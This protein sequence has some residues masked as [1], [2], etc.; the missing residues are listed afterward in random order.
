[1][2]LK[3]C[4]FMFRALAVL[5]FVGHTAIYGSSLSALAQAGDTP[6]P[7][8]NAHAVA[9]PLM[10]S[11]NRRYLV[12]QNGIPFLI[13]GDSPQALI[14]NVSLQDAEAY[15]KNRA[16]YGVNALWINIICNQGTACDPS[17]A[18]YDGIVPFTIPGDLSTPN[19][20]Y[21]TR[22][23]KMIALAAEA[24]IVVFL[25]PIETA[26]W[27]PVLRSNGKAKARA[28]GKFLGN[29]YKNSP[30]L[31][32]LHG[33]D[34]QSWR[35]ASDDALVRVV[36][37]GIRSIDNVHMATVELD[38][39]SSGSLDD[40]TWTALIDLDAAYT[41]LPA[42]AQVLTEYNRPNHMPIFLIETHYEF[43]KHGGT[44]G[45]H[46]SNLRRQAYWTMLSGATGQF[47]GSAFTWRF[48]SGWHTELD[49]QGIREFSYMS[50]LFA[51]RKWYDLVPDQDHQ[52]LT[53]GYGKFSKKRHLERNQYVTAA[54][55]LDGR[56]FMAYIPGGGKIA[57][58][59]T[60]L[61]NNMTARWYDPTSGTYR[62]ASAEP[63][64]NN[65]TDEFRPPGA[66]SSGDSDWVLV[67]E[68]T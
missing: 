67:L 41:Y 24:G 40:P 21:F 19:P 14:G 13:A 60:K 58:D 33:N 54:R 25:D 11:A 48:P 9:Y 3:L 27:L 53:A 45:I 49:T 56:L 10:V 65:K 38:F 34:F 15:I 46:I 55:T 51:H 64:V 7:A 8:E 6:A 39:P 50:H 68:S 5:A 37:E 31:V 63:L 2:T 52:V 44:D 17:G 66:N 61:A 35:N 57:V 29:R 28:Y 59:V 18:T 12:D 62:A 32:W 26:G 23:D 20:E 22:A 16:G 1:M 4:P 47:Y 42:Y 43:E 30:N 36:R